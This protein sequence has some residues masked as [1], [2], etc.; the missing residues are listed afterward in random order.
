MLFSTSTTKPLSPPEYGNAIPGEYGSAIKWGFFAVVGLIL[1]VVSVRLTN[2]PSPPPPPSYD[3][4]IAAEAKRVQQ[5]RDATAASIAAAAKRAQ[6]ERDDASARAAEDFPQN[7]ATWKGRVVQIA[8]LSK[9]RKGAEAKLA[10]AALDRDLDPLLRSSISKSPDVLALRKALDALRLPI[11]AL[12]LTEERATAE[13]ESR[14]KAQERA[15]EDAESR[16]KAAADAVTE[17]AGRAAYAKVLRQG[18]LDENMDIE[19][20]VSGKANERITLKFALFNAVSANKIQ[21]GDLLKE[22]GL[23]GFKRVDLTD[24]YDYH[25]SWNLQ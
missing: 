25:V 22:M 4:A 17:A 18:Y 21:K 10:L 19:V 20:T 23:L 6:Q 1:G 24:G 7:K 5:E 11:D 8:N 2:E 3:E 13:A 14:R 16:R 15:A 12:V 9:S